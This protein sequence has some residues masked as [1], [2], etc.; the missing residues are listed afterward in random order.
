MNCLR[1]ATRVKNMNMFKVC[2]TCLDNLHTI[3]YPSFKLS[4]DANKLE[5]C[6]MNPTCSGQPERIKREDAEQS[7]SDS[8]C[9][10]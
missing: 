1:L 8:D 2:S 9:L 4:K 3:T 6:P 7:T 5:K 10:K